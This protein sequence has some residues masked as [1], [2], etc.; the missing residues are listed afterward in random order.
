MDL[1]K[2]WFSFH[3]VSHEPKQRKPSSN[4]ALKHMWKISS[5][6]SHP[7]LQGTNDVPLQ[8]VAFP[9]HCSAQTQW[10]TQPS[11][12]TD[13]CPCHLGSLQPDT[14]L[15]RAP[16]SL[17]Q[18]LPKNPLGFGTSVCQIALCS[19]P[20]AIFLFFPLFQGRS[21]RGTSPARAQGRGHVVQS[22]G[23]LPAWPLGLTPGCIYG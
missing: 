16:S 18:V 21:Q 5:V 22:C 6:L 15:P 20:G 3:A 11:Q 23:H 10:P 7:A 4:I 19:G 8:K 12:G 1:S 14:E 17:L 9:H 2:T 13:N